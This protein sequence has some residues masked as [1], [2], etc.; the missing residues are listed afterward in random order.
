[1]LIEI[2]GVYLLVAAKS[3]L[4]AFL[5]GWS[6]AQLFALMAPIILVGYYIPVLGLW[7]MYRASVTRPMEDAIRYMKDICH[8]N[9]WQAS[10]IIGL[11]A[12]TGILFFGAMA[13]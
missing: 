4:L 2:A 6:A 5:P 9:R 3:G 10:G 8:Y 12:A 11:M 7:R 13:V 1:M